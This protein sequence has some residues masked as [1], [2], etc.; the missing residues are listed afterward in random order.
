[1]RDGLRI[2]A[3]AGVGVH[4]G[5][6]KFGAVHAAGA[7]LHAHPDVV[8]VQ[9]GGVH[10]VVQL[11]AAV[12]QSEGIGDVARIA[13]VFHHDDCATVFGELHDGFDL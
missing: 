4:G 8:E 9:F 2:F 10:R 3:P 5:Q 6:V 11:P 12:L 7:F 13:E 1:M